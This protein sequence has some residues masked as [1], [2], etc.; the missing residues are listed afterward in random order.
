M[1]LHAVVVFSLHLFHLFIWNIYIYIYIALA[2]LYFYYNFFP[3]LFQAYNKLNLS[4]ETNKMHGMAFQHW[5]DLQRTNFIICMFFSAKRLTKSRIFLVRDS[6]EEIFHIKHN[7]KNI[8]AQDDIKI[9]WIHFFFS[10]FKSC[11]SISL[12][13]FSFISLY[14]TDIFFLYK[15]IFRIC[16]MK[17]WID[18][19]HTYWR[20]W[21]T[22]PRWLRYHTNYTNSSSSV[23]LVCGRC[24]NVRYAR[25]FHVKRLNIFLIF[26]FSFHFIL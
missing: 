11:C 24:A 20:R 1:V 17:Y 18:V 19:D 16:I 4:F 7:R 5:L 22:D 15:I 21:P 25:A 10:A 9:L 8:F 2:Y 26:S 23:G 12:C 14:W 13:C 3:L 6:M